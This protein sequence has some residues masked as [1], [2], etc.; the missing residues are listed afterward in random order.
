[1]FAERRTATFSPASFTFASCSSESPVVQRTTGRVFS[2][3]TSR[4]SSTA[5]AFE[6]SITTSAC[7]SHSARL[8]N[9]GY[10]FSIPVNLSI[11]ATISIT[12][13]SFTSPEI[14]CPIFP[15]H[16]CIIALTILYSSLLSPFSC[17]SFHK[18]LYSTKGT[19]G[20]SSQSLFSII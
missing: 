15:L 5:A 19:D 11:P 1:M 13:S 9:T 14:T 16:P 12:S 20:Y 17:V 18:F 4:S 8:V 7:T 10:G 2:T 6:K 3:H